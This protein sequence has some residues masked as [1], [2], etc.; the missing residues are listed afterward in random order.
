M[1]GQEGEEVHLLLIHDLGTTWSEWL[2]SRLGHAL[3]PQKGPPVPI[4]QEA[5]WYSEP[6]WT[7][8]L[9]EKS[10]AFT[11]DRTSVARSSTP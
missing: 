10:F 1:E 6:V 2:A 9:E 5:R 11:G 8:R 3:A 4:V 7:Q